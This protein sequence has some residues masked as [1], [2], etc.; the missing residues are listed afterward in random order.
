[1]TSICDEI[2]CSKMCQP[3]L[4]NRIP[5]SAHHLIVTGKCLDDQPSNSCKRVNKE[6]SWFSCLPQ[7]P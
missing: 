4:Q 2:V 1:M 3:M 5:I 6:R 7:C